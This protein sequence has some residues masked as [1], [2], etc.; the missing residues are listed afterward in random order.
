MYIQSVKTQLALKNLQSKNTHIKDLHVTLYVIN[1]DKTHFCLALSSMFEMIADSSA[2]FN[3]SMF[4]VC[5]WRYPRII[6]TQED[7]PRYNLGYEKG[8]RPRGSAC[9]RV[10]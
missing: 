5:C 6:N 7:T 3:N 4:V 1:N 9:M 2:S 8:L 10:H